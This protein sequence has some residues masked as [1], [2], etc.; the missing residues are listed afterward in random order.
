MEIRS[1]H[2]TFT[3]L[4]YEVGKHVVRMTRNYL[5]LHILMTGKIS[6]CT[7]MKNKST[8]NCLSSVTVQI[9]TILFARCTFNH[10]SVFISP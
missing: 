10:V 7:Y 2:L 5:A 9:P 8:S 1:S 4:S 6:P 3:Y